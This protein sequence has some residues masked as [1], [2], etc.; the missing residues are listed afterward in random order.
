MSSPDPHTLVT[1]RPC[2]HCGTVGPTSVRAYP[3]QGGPI[4]ALCPTCARSPA[5][6][7]ALIR[8][9]RVEASPAREDAAL[10][11]G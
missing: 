11:D 5:Q 4:L 10:L 9:L 7:C 6:L 2:M 8:A 1:T 3:Q